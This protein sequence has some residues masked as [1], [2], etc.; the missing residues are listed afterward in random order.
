MP[1][2]SGFAMTNRTG[3]CQ[4]LQLKQGVVPPKGESILDVAWQIGL[5]EVFGRL[6]RYC[7]L[8]S[9]MSEAKTISPRLL[10]LLS[11]GKNQHCKS[12]TGSVP[13]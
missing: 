8:R 3:V 5:S 11:A 13:A 4:G 2:D 12:L 7:E 1:K 6:C 9:L 10:P